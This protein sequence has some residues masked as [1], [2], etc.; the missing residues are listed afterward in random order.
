MNDAQQN[1]QLFEEMERRLAALEPKGPEISR[2]RWVLVVMFIG[3]A[4]TVP[5]MLGIKLPWLTLVGMVVELGALAMFTVRQMKDVVPDFIDA[6]RK[7]AVDLDTHFL[8]YGAI[9]SWLSKVDQQ[10]RKRR[11]T[12][13]EA[14]LD[15]M[16]QRYPLLFGSVD[17]LGLLPVLVGLFFQ[18]QAIKSVSFYSGILAIMV[19]FLY[20]LAL[21]MSRFRLQLQSYARLLRSVEP[22]PDTGRL[23]RETASAA[24]KKLR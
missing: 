19:V 9:R 17:K 3:M 13:V 5:S 10:S 18:A 22:D 2:D 6:K 1:H 15:S 11:L 16:S 21:W 12:Y 14:R 8:E 23:A 24:A 7:F 4:M 20:L